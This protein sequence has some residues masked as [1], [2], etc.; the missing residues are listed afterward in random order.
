MRLAGGVT[1]AKHTPCSVEI[2]AYKLLRVKARI[3]GSR[4]QNAPT[5]GTAAGI[6]RMCGSGEFPVVLVDPWR[7][8][9]IAK[10]GAV[11]GGRV[12][13]SLR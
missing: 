1:S 2:V 7:W 4:S 9:G 11:E 13:L 8:V 6:V 3:L 12:V 10:P 5:G